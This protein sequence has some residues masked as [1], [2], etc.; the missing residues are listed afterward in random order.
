MKKLYYMGLSCILLFAACERESVFVQESPALSEKD[1]LESFAKILSKAVSE[2]E[3]LRAFIKEE[4]Q[5]KFDRNYDVFYPF[6]IN[7]EVEPGRTFRE[8]LLTYSDEY[9]LTSIENAAPLLN[10]FVPDWS[11]LGAFSILTWDTSSD[12]I[13]VSIADESV[14]DSHIIIQG[15]QKV[16]SLPNGSFPVTPTLIVK[17]NHRMRVVG[18]STKSGSFKYDYANEAFNPANTKARDYEI[19]YLYPATDPSSNIV[20]AESFEDMFPEA[21]QGWEEYGYGPTSCQRKM[22]Y[23]GI[24]NG[25]SLG[26]QNIHMRESIMAICLR[27]TSG[28]MDNSSDPKLRQVSKEGET[29]YSAEQLKT[30]LWSSG[31][32]VIQFV[33][34]VI[35]N[36]NQTK[37]LISSTPTVVAEGY[38]LFD[39]TKIKRTFYHKTWFKPRLYEYVAEVRDLA[40][41]WYYLPTPLVFD[42]WDPCGDSNIIN[43]SIFEQDSGNNT[44]VTAPAK[45]QRALSFSV[46]LPDSLKFSFNWS[47]NI[48]NT[49]QT[50]TRTADA[51]SLGCASI[52][53]IDYVVRSATDST[54]T[55]NTYSTGMIDFIVVPYAQ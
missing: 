13:A 55:L 24:H 22:I 17:S 35:D 34:N 44:T 26:V 23:Y 9:T 25:D 52:S 12:D 48:E 10:V 8:V 4:A 6:I 54:Y 40:P 43:V 28:C 50:Y 1:A 41:K 32:F 29:G 47:S 18:Q 27:L 33:A 51:D 21:V 46:E 14:N 53:F 11:W 5:R 15:G 38:K 49:T 42:R 3:P 7:A 36:N 2:N 20:E 31:Q 16:G 39:I 19:S 45:K 37:S 30:L